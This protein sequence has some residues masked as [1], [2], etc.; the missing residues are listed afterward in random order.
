M[1]D[2]AAAGPTAIDE[3]VPASPVSEALTVWAAAVFRTTP[4]NVATPAAA[5]TFAG[6]TP[7][8]SLEVRWTEPL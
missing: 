2:A 4:L 8:A 1:K 3:L 5:V 7:C 6:M